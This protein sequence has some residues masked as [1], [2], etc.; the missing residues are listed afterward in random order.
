MDYKRVTRPSTH[1]SIRFTHYC[2]INVFWLPSDFIIE[3]TKVLKLNKDKIQVLF[4]GKWFE[5][6]PPFADS[7][8]DGCPAP[9]NRCQLSRNPSV[10]EESHAV[11]FHIPDFNV[12][13]MPSFRSPEQ[14]WIFYSWESPIHY[15]LSE[16]QLKHVPPHY[17]FNL[18]F[19]YR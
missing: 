6:S 9:Y 18:T 8:F 19:T 1:S 4:W 2:F 12:S 10:L 5:K 3:Q 11:I 17:R 7:Y 15:P 14:R 16:I 13:D